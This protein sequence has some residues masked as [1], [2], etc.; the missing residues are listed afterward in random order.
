VASSLVHVLAD[1]GALAERGSVVD[2][3]SHGGRAG[4]YHAGRSG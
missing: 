4:C 2:Q 3:Y 1:A